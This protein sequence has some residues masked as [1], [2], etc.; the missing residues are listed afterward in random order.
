M[1]RK[2]GCSLAKAASSVAAVAVGCMLAATAFAAP[3]R[4][5]LPV[6]SVQF[7][8]VD[9]PTSFGS[10]GDPPMST[11]VTGVN[12]AGTL[13]G[14]WQAVAL[15]EHGFIEPAGGQPTSFDA[16]GSSC[17]T[18]SGGINDVG[19][20]VGNLCSCGPG[21]FLFDGFVRSPDG[22][23]TELDDPLSIPANNSPTAINDSGLIVGNY[24][25]ASGYNGFVYSRGT[26]TTLDVPGAFGTVLT[27]VN[28]SGAMVGVYF[29]GNGGLHGFLYRNGK[30]TT[31]DAPGAGTNPA[32]TCALS[33]SEGT[34]ALG[35]SASGA[36]VGSTCN[37]S[38]NFGWVL[39]NGQYSPLNDPNAAPALGGTYV[40]SISEDGHFVAGEYIDTSGA[41]HGFV[42]TLTP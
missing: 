5:A 8:T 39:Q 40:E 10:Y 19:A 2:H 16:L 14:G 27:G 30:F 13:V 6:G 12:N 42:A 4:A 17:C 18:T 31:I 35:I 9:V 33:G 28:N 22:S 36:I 32:A 26:F 24:I 11:N 23:F 15:D 25:D 7:R 29:N 3:A 34:Q 1:Y 37:D 20:S 21:P 38:G 41:Q